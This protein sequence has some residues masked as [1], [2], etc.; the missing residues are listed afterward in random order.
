MVDWVEVSEALVSYI[1]ELLD[2]W[3]S[4]VREAY[5]REKARESENQSEGGSGMNWIPI[6]TGW[7]GGVL[8]T[9]DP[10]RILQYPECQPR[11]NGL[12]LNVVAEYAMDMRNYD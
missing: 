8:E 9:I 11:V 1:N 4:A 12:D 7:S 10:Q 2:T 3:D 5:E 6:Q